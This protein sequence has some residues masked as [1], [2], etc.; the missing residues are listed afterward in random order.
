VQANGDVC[1]ATL[2]NS[3]ITT[4]SPKGKVT[5]KSLAQYKDPLVTNIAFG[6]KGMKT[7]WIT[8][9]GRGLLI[10]TPWP[11]PGLELAFNA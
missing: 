6:G 3:G 10:Q 4:I 5:F 11:K 9:S 2:I 8:V 1:V 7:A